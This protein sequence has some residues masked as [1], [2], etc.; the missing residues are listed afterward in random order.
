MVGSSIVTQY[1]GTCG[2]DLHNY[3]SRDNKRYKKISSRQ[4][5]ILDP[6]K[7]WKDLVESSLKIDMSLVMSPKIL[8]NMTKIMP[9]MI[10]SL[11]PYFM[12]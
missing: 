7:I 12:H 6:W 5:Y 10:W 3:K 2:G 4:Y 1:L 11:F 9:H 8:M